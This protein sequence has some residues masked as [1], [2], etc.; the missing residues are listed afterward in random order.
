MMVTFAKAFRRHV[1]CPDEQI[2]AAATIGDALAAYFGRHPQVRG[3]VL[4]DAGRLRRHVTVFAD[5]E[6]LNHREA[7]AAP[8]TSTTTIHVFQALSGG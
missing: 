5:D 2:A 7:L 1:D 3:Y 8:V 6:Q 4:D